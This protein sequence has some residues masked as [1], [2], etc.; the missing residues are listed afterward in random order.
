MIN[1]FVISVLNRVLGIKLMTM[2]QL[3]IYFHETE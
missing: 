1:E 2:I 3:A